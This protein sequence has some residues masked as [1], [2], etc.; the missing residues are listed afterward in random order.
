MNHRTHAAFIVVAALGLAACD[1]PGIPDSRPPT[2]EHVTPVRI[3]EVGVSAP[4]RDLRLPGVVRAA[5]RAEPAFLHPGHLAE[6]FVTRG[7][8]VVAGQRLASL[9]NPALGPALASAEARVRELDERLLQLSA[10]HERARE[11]HARGLAS[12]E[13]LDRTLAERNAARQ[14]RAQALAAVSQARDQLADA[15]L[16][17]PFEATV[18]DLLVEPGDFV[19]AGQPVM[20]LA[21]DDGLEV[22]VQLPEGLV[23][24]L[25]PGASV[26]VRAVGSGRRLEG[27]V[28][29]VGVARSGR[30]A[31]AVI[32]LPQSD[33]WE[34]GISVHVAVMLTEEPAL[35]V[36]L[37]AVVDPG[38]GQTRLFRINDERA[39]LVPVQV[40]RLVGDRVIVR[41]ELAAGERVV[42]AGHQQLLDGEAVRVLP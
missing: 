29:E 19:Q 10:D 32:A 9:Q 28:R 37:A 4:V 34:P 35:T 31:P 7:E 41:G 13:L 16:R 26:E 8:R 5:Q 40:G 30:P 11:L 38:T 1:A 18:G 3:A 36:P 24:R 42:I 21:G 6:R 23:R 17:A 39:E 15:V 33:E 27:R 12:E 20:V 22:E 25:A 14:A 2:A